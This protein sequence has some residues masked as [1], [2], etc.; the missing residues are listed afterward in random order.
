MKTVSLRSNARHENHRAAA[1]RSL[2]LSP[3]PSFASTSLQAISGSPAPGTL[4][5]AIHAS[6]RQ[7][8][9]RQLIQRIRAW[10]SASSQRQVSPAS[11][12]DGQPFAEKPPDRALLPGIGNQGPIQ[13]KHR[14][15]LSKVPEDKKK[16]VQDKLEELKR[17]KK[18]GKLGKTATWATSPDKDESRDDVYNKDIEG[19]RKAYEEGIIK[20]AKEEGVDTT[21][22]VSGDAY[23]G[24]DVDENGV[25]IFRRPD[26]GKEYVKDMRGTFVPRY[27]RRELNHQDDLTGGIKTQGISTLGKLKREKGYGPGGRGALTWG[28]RE[29][30]QQSIGGGGNLFALSHTSTKRPIL[31]N[32]HE[33]F[34]AKPDPHNH[35]GA[36]LTDLAKMGGGKF[37][38]QWT[39][40]PVTGH[41][42][43]LPEGL[44]QTVDKF[45]KKKGVLKAG[46]GAKRD[47]KVLLSGYRN[48]EVV[49]EAVPKEAII[50]PDASWKKEEGPKSTYHTGASQ[51]GQSMES[52]RAKKR[53]EVL[54]QLHWKKVEDQYLKNRAKKKIKNPPPLADAIQVD[55]ESGRY[56]KS[57]LTQSPYWKKLLASPP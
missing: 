40:D 26:T 39:L 45:D 31:S 47:K 32:D 4:T 12:G 8:A 34:G 3:V 52:F 36:I 28:Q 30:L 29:F 19:I 53:E 20:L 35:S 18:S 48:M 38:A 44:H 49:A 41:K 27:I 5:A 10:S 33:S 1:D 25:K 54:G 46:S 21:A 37:A 15:D 13:R 55:D 11:S 56:W 51:R 16:N 43:P 14:I 42:V 24:D 6:P 9:Q 17:A 2:S 22:L 57:E 7:A 50:Q 23:Y